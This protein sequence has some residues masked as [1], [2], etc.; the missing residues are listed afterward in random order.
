MHDAPHMNANACN[1]AGAAQGSMETMTLPLARQR[2]CIHRPML[3]YSKE[4]LGTRCMHE[5]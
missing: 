5:T 2:L 3:L 4:L 1:A